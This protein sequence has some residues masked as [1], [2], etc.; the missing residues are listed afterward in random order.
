MNN[1]N[2]VVINIRTW[3]YILLSLPL[4]SGCFSEPTVELITPGPEIALGACNNFDANKNPYFGDLHTHTSFSLDAIQFDTKNDPN[5]A[6]RFAKGEAISLPPFDKDGNSTRTTQLE[7]PLD[8]AGVS[9]HAEFLAEANICFNLDS[10]QYFSPFCGIMRGSTEGTS[11]L[12]M[13]AFILGL[14][15]LAVPGGNFKPSVC[16]HS[17]N[18]ALCERREAYAWVST[19]NAAEKHYD[20]SENCEFTTFIGYEWSGTPSIKNKHRNVFFKDSNVPQRPLSY[21][22]A[23]HPI[24]LWEKLDENCTN[25]TSG[26]EVLAI[27]HNSN[28]GG[29]EMFNPVTENGAPYT[30]AIAA[31]RA[32]MEP[33]VEI[34]Q[35][36]GASECINSQAPFGSSDEMC[37]F[38]L[39]ISDICTGDE[40][41][42]DTCSPLCSDS[43]LGASLTGGCIEPSDFI[44]STLKRG[45]AEESRLIEENGFGSNPFQFGFIGSTDNHN[46]TPGATDEFSWEGH[47]GT[48]DDTVEE[49]VGVAA[50]LNNPLTDKL[51]EHLPAIEEL[52]SLGNLGAYSAGGLAVVWAEQNSRH[53]I[54]DSMKKKETYATSGTRIV[55]RMFAGDQIAEDLCADPDFAAKGYSQGIAM[56]SKLPSSTQNPAFAVSA[57]MDAG[58]QLHPG[59]PLQ[60]IQIVKGWEENGE[61]HEKVFDVAGNP[62]NGASVNTETCETVGSGFSNLCTVWHDP[63]FNAAQ[64]AFYYAKV[65]ENPTCRW[66]QRQCNISKNEQGLTCTDINGDAEHPLAACCNGTLPSTVQERAWSSPVWHRAS[67]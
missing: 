50:A 64:P 51:T 67:L 7:R 66:N 57:L 40:T 42:S 27:P 6:Y 8:F 48:N 11:P 37:D 25:T 33:L 10:T 41:D 63:E 21:F 65:L 20:R 32:R 56:G 46:A 29:G 17:K 61:T 18:K 43:V 52:T 39:I 45:L 26:C 9:D 2:L 59:T 47:V 38:E 30:P 35:H 31:Q 15:P 60:R 22:D 23:P 14:G 54:F 62:N 4:M 49:R 53:A 58:T 3:F 5:M 19:Q 12:D 24:E 36:K 44:R 55:L 34:Y 13:V 1:V 28:L 16:S